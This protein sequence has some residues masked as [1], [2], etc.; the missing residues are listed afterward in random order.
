M[1]L[2]PSVVRAVQSRLGSTYDELV[3]VLLDV[4][5]PPLFLFHDERPRVV[6]ARARAVDAIRQWG[7][8]EPAVVEGLI[9]R[10]PQHFHVPDSAEALLESV[11]SVDYF[12]IPEALFEPAAATSPV[13]TAAPTLVDR[14]DPDG[15]LKMADLDAGPHGVFVGDLSL[16]YH[17]FLRRNFGS[18]IHYELVGAILRIAQHGDVCARLAIDHRRLRHREEH[19]EPFEADYWYGPPLSDDKLDDPFAVG[20][21]IHG[22]PE[23]GSSLLHPYLALSARWSRD[24]HLKTVE[25]EELV[26]IGE[27]DRV[28]VRYLHA[29]RDTQR[30]CFI[31]CD[32]AVK[33]YEAATY[34]TTVADF[35]DRGRSARYRKVFRLDGTIA[36]DDWSLVTALWFR[37]NT[38][39]VEYLSG[40]GREGA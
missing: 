29:I 9:G 8:D 16:H 32:G 35:P 33:A 39:I 24:A 5:L 4:G 31:H 3:R 20:T 30:R 26:P 2:D 38:L 7:A 23:G 34:P 11:P 37:G 17:Q 10:L 1:E 36:T 13:L 40:V 6:A 18:N 19:S 22:D 21:T 15:L 14:M 25:I 12:A 28:L 27:D